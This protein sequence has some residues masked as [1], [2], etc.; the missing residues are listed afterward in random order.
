MHPGSSGIL[1]MT[2]SRNDE[3]LFFFVKSSI[4]EV[5]WFLRQQTKVKKELKDKAAMAVAGHTQRTG[6]R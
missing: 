5:S 1:T 3:L 2:D 4:G 6:L